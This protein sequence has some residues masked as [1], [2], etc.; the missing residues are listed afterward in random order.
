MKVPR[1]PAE[2]KMVDEE[3]ETAIRDLL[4]ASDKKVGGSDGNS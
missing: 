4:E 3:G 1:A 2:S